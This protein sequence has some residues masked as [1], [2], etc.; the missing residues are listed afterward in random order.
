[1]DPLDCTV[2]DLADATVV[3]VRGEVDMVNAPSLREVLIDVLSAKPSTHLIVDLGGVDFLDSTGI[4]VLVGA[5]RRV[6]ANGGWFTAVVAT[7]MVRKTLQVTGL[8]RAW[9]VT[10]SVEDALEDV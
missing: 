2:E 1:M 5:H 9:R 3:R 7:P 4:S 8:L 10:G 6:T